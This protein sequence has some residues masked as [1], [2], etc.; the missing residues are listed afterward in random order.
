MG[1]LRDTW[2]AEREQAAA[3][4]RGRSG[5]PRMLLLLWLGAI[6]VYLWR[7]PPQRGLFDWPNL[8]SGVNLG[9]H[10]LG[11][12]VFGPFGMFMAVLGGSLLQCIAPIAGMVSL[13]KQGDFFGVAICGGW[14]STNLF[15]VA[16]YMADAQAQ[17]LA[18]VSPFSGHPLHDW[19]YL[20]SDLG[21]LG[22][23]EELG[24][25]TKIA[26]TLVMGLSLGLGSWLVWRMLR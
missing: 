22:A 16:T 15:G 11:H 1:V 10:E 7:D 26:A 8:F 18:L 20:F 4:C 3:W 2:I 17:Q 6:L 23:C 12:I 14:L 19:H 21:W 5:I 13:R 9:I 24:F 25:L